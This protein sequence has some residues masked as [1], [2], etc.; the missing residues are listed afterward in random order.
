MKRP[1]GFERIRS[2]A[3]AFSS[4]LNFGGIAGG[5]GICSGKNDVIGGRLDPEGDLNDWERIEWGLGIFP[6]ALALSESLIAEWST[7][8]SVAGVGGADHW[9]AALS[10]LT[11]EV[12]L[13]SHTPGR[14][15]REDA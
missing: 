7:S 6:R 11:E 4:V 1:A 3:G 2:V 8:T 10:G 9:L 5:S 13:D 14:L 15:R 12:E